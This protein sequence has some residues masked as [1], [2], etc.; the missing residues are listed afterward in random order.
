METS[1]VFC[2]APLVAKS[3]F[4]IMLEP[5][6]RSRNENIGAQDLMDYEL[7]EGIVQSKRSWEHL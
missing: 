4:M 6:E 1:C 7:Y 5:K 2:L 3:R